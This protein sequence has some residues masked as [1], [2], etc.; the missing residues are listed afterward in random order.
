M[1]QPRRSRNTG[2]LYILL[3]LAAVYDGLLAFRHRLSDN[4]LFDGALGVVLGLYICSRGA[5]NMLDL[6]LY[7]RLLQFRWSSKYGQAL[8]VALNV[9]V[10]VAGWSV[11][12][13]GATQ[14]ARV[15][16]A[17]VIPFRP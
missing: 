1:N 16:A 9:L 12:A 7:G 13:A 17:N 8:W 10:L 14:L 11:I 15:P 4:I 5:A 2:L 6:I 3:A